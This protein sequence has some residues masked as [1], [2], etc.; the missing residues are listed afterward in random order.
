MLKRSRTFYIQVL[1]NEN[2]IK[3][4]AGVDDNNNLETS[5]PRNGLQT[6]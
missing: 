3:E 5:E 2:K 4:D 6:T 1:Q